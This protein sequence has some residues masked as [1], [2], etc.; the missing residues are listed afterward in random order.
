[1]DRRAEAG[2][3][4]DDERLEEFLSAITCAEPRRW[5]RMNSLRSSQNVALRPVPFRVLDQVVAGYFA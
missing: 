3:F 1:M 4:D 2:M 5:T